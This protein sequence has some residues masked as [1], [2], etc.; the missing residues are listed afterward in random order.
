MKPTT[1]LCVLTISCFPSA[2]LAAGSS[3]PTPPEPTETTTHCEDGQIWD[4]ETETCIEPDKETGLSDDLIYQNAR[5]FAY[6]GQYKNA[7]KLLNL[8][9]NQSDPRI[10][11]YKGFV[12]RKSGNMEKALQYYQRALEISPK[13]NL[14][15]SYYGQALVTIGKTDAARQQLALIAQNNGIGSWP[16][17][18]LAQT[19]SGPFAI[20]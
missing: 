9:S 18:A 20:Y 17:T 6:D 10:L 7:L 5:E 4:A 16:H 3:T 8:A 19:L 2:T 12:N 11:N 14:A 1:L 15:R 13:Y